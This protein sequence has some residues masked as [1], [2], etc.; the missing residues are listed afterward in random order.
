[1]PE[2]SLGELF[3]FHGVTNWDQMFAEAIC[4]KCLFK[5][6]CKGVHKCDAIN[7]IGILGTKAVKHGLDA[8]VF[9]TNLKASIEMVHI[10]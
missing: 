10:N 8:Q 2:T 7:I 4:E 9:A 6:Q 1:M 3:R 5:S